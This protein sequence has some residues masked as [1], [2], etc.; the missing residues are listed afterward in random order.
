MACL[1]REYYPALVSYAIRL[2]GESQSYLAE[3]C[4]QESIYKTYLAKDRISDEASLKSYL[5]T[6][7]R[8][9]AISYIRKSGSKNNYLR[10]IELTQQDITN[11][12]IE[13]ETLR[14]LFVAIDK[15]PEKYRQIFEM[16]FEQ[17]LKTAQI[18]Q[19][20]GISESTIKKR[21]SKMIKTL[22]NELGDIPKSILLLL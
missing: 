20:L 22:R 7:I 8:N 15:L 4:V 1:Y 10:Q 6:S 18:A 17:G 2:L 16:S 13:Q 9:R 3:D 5:Y 14:K 19:Q 11:S 12:I 21:K